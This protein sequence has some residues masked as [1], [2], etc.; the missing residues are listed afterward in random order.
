MNKAAQ[1]AAILTMDAMITPLAHPDRSVMVSL[2]TPCEMLHVIGLTPYSAEGFSCY[3]SGTMAEER[4]LQKAEE[5][6]IPETFCSYHK[7]FLGAAESGVMM[8]GGVSKN[9]G[10]VDAIE[11]KLGIKLYISDKAQLCGALGAALYAMEL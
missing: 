5:E 11:K 9:R 10:V 2:F 6:G 1:C 8:T 7:I 4:F 3:I